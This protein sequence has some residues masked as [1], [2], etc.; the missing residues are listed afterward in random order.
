MQEM[1]KEKMLRVKQ[2][3][4]VMTFFSSF[5]LKYPH[6][7]RKTLFFADDFFYLQVVCTYVKLQ[8]WRAVAAR[9]LLHLVNAKAI[10][11]VTGPLLLLILRLPLL[12]R[13]AL[14]KKLR[15]SQNVGRTL[16][17]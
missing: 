11:R 14:V 8:S 3:E 13:L 1:P 15:R 12:P 6:S 17:E 4:R 10:L 7:V 2:K 16:S 5:K 9:K